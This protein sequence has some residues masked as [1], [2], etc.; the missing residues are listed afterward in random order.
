[1]LHRTIAFKWALGGLC[2]A[3]FGFGRAR[4]PFKT[5]EPLLVDLPGSRRRRRRA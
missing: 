1:M 2:A 5:L 3:A 4:P